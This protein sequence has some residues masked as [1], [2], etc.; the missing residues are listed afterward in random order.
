MKITYIH[1]SAI[2]RVTGE[3]QI[4]KNKWRKFNKTFSVPQDCNVPKIQAKFQTPTLTI[5]LPKITPSK[6]PSN[7]DLK[8]N[9]QKT[10]EI[11]KQPQTIQSDEKGKELMADKKKEQKLDEEKIKKDK[12]EAEMRNKTLFEDDEKNNKKRKESLMEAQNVSKMEESINKKIK[13]GDKTITDNPVQD[14]LRGELKSVSGESNKLSKEE[15]GIGLKAKEVKKR[16][17]ELGR[18]VSE[19]KHSLVNIGVAILVIAAL[20]AYISYTYG[21]SSNSS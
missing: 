1:S 21:S 5:T 6:L 8:N 9:E 13:N 18:E 12:E 20:G 2:I 19:D 3:K 4:S 11:P 17:V 7:Q 16:V 15:D 10:Q 14:D